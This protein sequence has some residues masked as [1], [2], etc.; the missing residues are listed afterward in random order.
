MNVCEKTLLQLISYSQFGVGDNCFDHDLLDDVLSVAKVQ[1]VLGLVISSIPT[2]L[3]TEDVKILQD[4]QT[5]NYIRYLHEEDQLKKLL[6][7][8]HIPFVILKGNAAA[9]NYRT[10]SL[11]MMG[12]VDFIVLEDDFERTRQLMI[13]SGYS[14]LHEYKEGARHMAFKKNKTE[15]EL[16]HHFSPIEVDIERYIKDGIRDRV[17]GNIMGYEIPML[18]KLANGLVL[19]V[20]MRTHMKSGLG[21]RHIVDW[22]MYV[23]AELDDEFWNNEFSP[24][25]Q[26]KGMETFA[27]VVTRMCQKYLGLSDSVT[28]CSDA[29]EEL[30]ESLL[31][32][33]FSSGNFGRGQGK[34]NKTSAIIT[35]FKREGLF[36]RLQ[37]AGMF[38]WNLYKKHH[39]LKPFCWIYQVFRYMRQ[40][41]KLN[42]SSLQ[43][44][45]D[46]KR[47]S[48]RYELLKKLGI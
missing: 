29:D 40:G 32:S 15:F 20:H 44:I 23:N 6:N 12:D 42:R 16:H 14:V 34:G 30:C 3:M 2:D 11:R 10:P 5:A 48:D 43:L 27:K 47:G 45:D 21:L 24:I 22:M 31:D 9:I 33:V 25:V 41:F 13:D 37:R 36:R 4:R 18:P 26:E 1:S 8:N 17:F 35:A 38:N 39:W 7:D 28:W 46:A 19:L